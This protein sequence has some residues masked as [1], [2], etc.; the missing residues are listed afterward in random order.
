MPRLIAPV[1]ASPH[2]ESRPL[3]PAMPL[4][5]APPID[6]RHWRYSL[7]SLPSIVPA[8]PL[9]RAVPVAAERR[10]YSSAPEPPLGAISLVFPFRCSISVLSPLRLRLHRGM[11]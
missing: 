9:G 6:S 3:L 1:R 5:A 10:P 4:S 11:P 8:A 7:L 2:R